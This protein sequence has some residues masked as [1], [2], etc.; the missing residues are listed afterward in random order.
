M[1][2]LISI[3]GDAKVEEGSAKYQ[4]AFNLGKA[5]VDNGYRVASG[6]LNGIMRAAFKGAKSSKKAVDGDTIAITPM[7]DRSV[8]NEYA[9]IVVATGLDVFRNVIVANSDAVI[10]VGGGS[11]TM[12]EICNAWALRKM[13]LATRNVDGW[14]GK[15]ADTRLDKRIRLENFDKDII[16]GI[17]TADEAIKLLDQFLPT[18]LN[19][20][21][22]RITKD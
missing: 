8:T 15:V 7:F 11:G 2:K 21:Y 4:M 17:D 14:S 22:I 6:G 18:Y 5:L 13:I 9:D 20:K 19:T 10:A 16:F 12:C 1:R 3:I